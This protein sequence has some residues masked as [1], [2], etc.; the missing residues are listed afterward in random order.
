MSD[1]QH[2]FSPRAVP[3]FH[4]RQLV[5]WSNLEYLRIVINISTNKYF[6]LCVISGFLGELI[7]K[8]ITVDTKF[9]N[10]YIK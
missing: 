6:Q 10:N 5:K 7:D 1:V 8:F 2:L 4:S 9:L 3:I